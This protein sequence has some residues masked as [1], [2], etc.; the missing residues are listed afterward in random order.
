MGLQKR[1]AI[2]GTPSASAW[3]HGLMQ[4]YPDLCVRGMA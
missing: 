3:A 2:E 1:N 4:T